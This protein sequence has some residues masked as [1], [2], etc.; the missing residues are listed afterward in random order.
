MSFYL[1]RMNLKS[2]GTF[3][4]NKIRKERGGSVLCLEEV[5][6]PRAENKWDGGGESHHSLARGIVVVTHSWDI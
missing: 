2:V 5:Q 4:G 1:Q 3:L 6:K